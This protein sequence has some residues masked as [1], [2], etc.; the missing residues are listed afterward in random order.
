VWVGTRIKCVCPLPVLGAPILS[1][2]GRLGRDERCGVDLER[3]GVL[4]E[5][6]DSQGD[7]SVFVGSSAVTPQ[8]FL[9]LFL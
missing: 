7:V 9:S 1:A 6:G 3:G 5:V 2:Q 4:P 8:G